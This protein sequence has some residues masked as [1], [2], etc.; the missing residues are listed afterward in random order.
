VS[1]SSDDVRSHQ[2]SGT[3]H[4]YDAAEVEEFRQRVVDAL[5]THEVA[6]EAV[7][8]EPADVVGADSEDTLAAAQ[9]VRQQ[10]V[11]LAE[12]ML[13]DVMGASEDDTG[14]LATWQEAVMLRALAEEEMAFA[15]EEARRLP[16]M[17]AAERDGIRGKRITPY[18]LKCLAELSGGKTLS[19][20][21]ALLENNARVAGEIAAALP[22]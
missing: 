20:N 7:T 11:H 2:F 4:S 6:A 22:V 14:S 10:A 13:R 15:R 9:R 19:A 5:A 12:R 3:E 16:A 21:I 8:T 1:I 18:L 17:A